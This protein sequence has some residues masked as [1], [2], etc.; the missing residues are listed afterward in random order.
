M[1]RHPIIWNMS[2]EELQA[3]VTKFAS[4]RQAA[5]SL[6]CSRS[7]LRNCARAKGV[8]LTSGRGD[9]VRRMRAVPVEA[10]RDALIAHDGSPT[11]LAILFRTN[12]SAI[13]TACHDLGLGDLLL[14]R[15]DADNV[16]PL[17]D[18]TSYT[19]SQALADARAAGWE[20]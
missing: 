10:M 14:R 19:A 1:N 4:I 5:S 6:G 11:R 8:A 18:M 16:E 12:A 2:A 13:I 20:G 17:D 15:E 9:D 3:E 7:S